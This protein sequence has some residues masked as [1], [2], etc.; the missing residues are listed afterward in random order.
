MKH[1]QTIIP[2]VWALVLYILY[3]IRW[4]VSVS[5]EG[6]DPEVLAVVI[7]A[8]SLWIAAWV[9]SHWICPAYRFYT[10][11]SFLRPFLQYQPS[12]VLAWGIPALAMVWELRPFS[13]HPALISILVEGILYAICVAGLEEFIFRGLIQQTLRKTLSAIDSVLY[14]ALLFGIGHVFGMWGQPMAVILIRF[15]WTAGLG[16]YLGALYEKTKSLTLVTVVHA[17]VDMTSILYLFSA[18]DSFTIQTASILLFVFYG[19]GAYG[20][21]L[22]KEEAQ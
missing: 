20:L 1:N 10:K 22:L 16:L 7:R 12:I 19:L 11:G 21:F 4:P 17:L 14:G 5:L 8:G 9:L 13:H 2:L 15:L 6:V 18:K 3:L